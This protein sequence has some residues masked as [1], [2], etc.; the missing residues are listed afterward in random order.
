LSTEDAPA[1]P[2]QGPGDQADNDR[3]TAAATENT[4]AKDDVASF[5]GATAEQ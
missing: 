5:D 2:E 1:E 4:A 3:N